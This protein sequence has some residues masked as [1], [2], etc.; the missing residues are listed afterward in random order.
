MGDGIAVPVAH[1]NGRYPSMSEQTNIQNSEYVKPCRKCGAQE[2]TP[3]GDCHPCRLASSRNWH[4]NNPDK[5]AASIEQRQTR[6]CG[7]CGAI[8]R[9]Q[10]G[11]CRPCAIL[12]SKNR[13]KDRQR[14]SDKKYR[15]KNRE[16]YLEKIR[17]KRILNPIKFRERER[18]KEARRKGAVGKLSQGIEQKLF[19]A[20]RGLCV[21][22]NKPLGDNYHLDHIMPLALGGTNTDDNVQ[23]LLAR[24]NLQKGAKH[25]DEW[26]KILAQKS[27][28]G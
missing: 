8:D 23:L 16:L 17:Q 28:T 6:P 24:C 5:V 21:C 15:Y 10:S 25:P 22:C 3:K 7:K 2:R 4:K 1:I 20:Q 26:R 18:E 13:D 19:E 11:P 12:R 27:Y 9:Y 14:E